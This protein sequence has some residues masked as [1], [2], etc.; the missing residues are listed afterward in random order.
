M[1]INGLKGEYATVN[2]IRMFYMHGGGDKKKPLVLVHGLFQTGMM[3]RRVAAKLME[4]HYLIVPDNRG[5]GLSEKPAK[6]EDLTKRL[7]AQDIYELLTHLGIDKCVMLSHDRGARIARTFAM[8]YPEM[9]LGVSFMDMLPTEYIYQ[10]MT[11]TQTGSHHWDQLFKLASPMAEDLLD[12]N[13]A[14]TR[15]YVNNFYNRT[16]GFVDILKEDGVY[17]YYMDCILAPG[18]MMAMLND[19]RAAYHIDVPRI[20]AA[21][22][23]GERISIPVQLLWGSKGNASKSP[24]M[25]I[26]KVR[27][28]NSIEGSVVPSGHYLAEEEPEITQDLLLG[29]SDKCFSKA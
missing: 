5:Y 20:R 13:A 3:W 27:C 18:A 19:Y 7:Q 14:N 12:G 17:D 22:D 9:L 23:K 26:Y 16:P 2:G 4:D 11:S 15:I 21:L 28:S 24:I 6:M 1:I 25:D 10:E 8:D 29:F